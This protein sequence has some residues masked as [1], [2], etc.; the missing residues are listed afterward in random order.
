M[1]QQGMLWI[2]K[3]DKIVK[4]RYLAQKI[5]TRIVIICVKI[6]CTAENIKEITEKWEKM[7]KDKSVCSLND[8]LKKH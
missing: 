6:F 8:A 3:G 1:V 4:N 2:K 7:Y 5:D